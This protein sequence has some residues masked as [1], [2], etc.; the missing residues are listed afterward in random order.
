MNV[1]DDLVGESITRFDG[2]NAEV[3][4][5][6]ADVRRETARLVQI[7]QAQH[8]LL[9]ELQANLASRERTIGGLEEWVAGA[10]E[11][12]RKAE[13]AECPLERRTLEGPAGAAPGS[14]GAAGQHEATATQIE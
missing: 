3:G 12:L 10:Q 13:E 8:R 5:L 7:V 14:T 6:S 2:G 4:S 11:A 1:V 9:M